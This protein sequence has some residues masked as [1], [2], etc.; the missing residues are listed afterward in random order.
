MC[1]LFV[2]LVLVFQRWLGRCKSWGVAWSMLSGV[3]SSSI[4]LNFLID[5]NSCHFLLHHPCLPLVIM[6][7]YLS[8][9]NGG[10]THNGHIHSSKPSR[11]RYVQWHRHVK[12]GSIC[13]QQQQVLN[14]S[15]DEA[16]RTEDQTLYFLWSFGYPRSMSYISSTQI[17]EEWRF[18]Y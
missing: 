18:E 6:P 2:V 5:P 17:K 14:I 13:C 15:S 7:P 4:L 16:W 9:L 3:V 8:H 12:W 1:C 10:S 11:K